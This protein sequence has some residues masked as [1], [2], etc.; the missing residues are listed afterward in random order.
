MPRTNIDARLLIFTK[1]P[2]P[3]TVKTRLIP[4]LGQQGAAALQARF[5]AHALTV[6]RTAAIGPMELHCAPDCSDAFLNLCAAG[7]GAALVPQCEGDLGARMQ[8]AFERALALSPRALLIG[9]DCPPLTVR[10]L[11]DADRALRADDAVF[12]PAEDG[13]YAL[14]GLKRCDARLF[15]GIA[16]GGPTVMEDTRARLHALGWT[17]RELETLWDV[18][19]TEDYQRLLDSGLLDEKRARA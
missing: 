2:R 17:W 6:A 11:R 14:I 10:H 1:A 13:G 15:R 8:H 5:I 4:L 9:T 19:R 18:D 12:A 3:G 7:Y 16:W